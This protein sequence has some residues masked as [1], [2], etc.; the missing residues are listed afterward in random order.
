MTEQ[1]RTTIQIPPESAPWYWGVAAGSK[2]REAWEP[3]FQ[4]QEAD[5]ATRSRIYWFYVGLLAG[6]EHGMTGESSVDLFLSGA[7]TRA[8]QPAV[9]ELP[10]DWPEVLT[11]AQQDALDNLVH[12]LASRPASQINNE[13]SD[14]QLRFLLANGFTYPQVRKELGLTEEDKA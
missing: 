14:S 10:E 1:G 5:D 11:E 9:A 8:P 7:S 4:E 6:S 13:G 2:V 3:T 12:D